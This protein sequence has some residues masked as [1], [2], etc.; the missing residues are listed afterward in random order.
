MKPGEHLVNKQ[1]RLMGEILLALLE[2]K[3]AVSEYLVQV[4]A[5]I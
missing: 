1:L 2:G 4:K 3:S 5:T